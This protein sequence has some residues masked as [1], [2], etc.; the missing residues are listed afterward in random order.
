[1]GIDPRELSDEDLFRE[2]RHVHETRS[3]TLRHGSE[4]AL[5][6]HTTRTAE[7]EIEYLRR[8]PE[9]EVDPERLREGARR[10]GQEAR[11]T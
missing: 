6:H 11:S 5:A 4:D 2:M 1:M 3:D 10:R 7:L 8:F 9:R